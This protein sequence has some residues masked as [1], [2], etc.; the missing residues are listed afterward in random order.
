MGMVLVWDV[1]VFCVGLKFLDL[2]FVGLVLGRGRT[3]VCCS[4][5]VL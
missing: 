4:P 1:F 5:L 2:V 3:R